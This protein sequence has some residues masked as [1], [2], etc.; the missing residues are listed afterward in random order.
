MGRQTLQGLLLCNLQLSVSLKHMPACIPSLDW[1][2][3]Q[4]VFLHR[5]QPKGGYG[6][7]EKGE[8]KRNLFDDSWG[9]S[10]PMSWECLVIKIC[11]PELN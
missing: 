2:W 6:K 5:A 10:A 11:L 4:A 3:V 8:T 1:W 7:Y 9:Q